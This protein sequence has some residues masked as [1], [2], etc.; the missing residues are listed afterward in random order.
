MKFR[1]LSDQFEEKKT[2]IYYGQM[3]DAEFNFRQCSFLSEFHNLQ[4]FWSPSIHYAQ[5]KF[6]IS[7]TSIQTGFK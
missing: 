5:I 4:T 6:S 1:L 2:W 7:I 3:A